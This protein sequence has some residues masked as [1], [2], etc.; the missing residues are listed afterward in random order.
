MQKEYIFVFVYS[1]FIIIKKVRFKGFNETASTDCK[2]IYSSRD[3][4]RYCFKKEYLLPGFDKKDKIYS[5]EIHQYFPKLRYDRMLIKLFSKC[6]F[7]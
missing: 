5:V 1:R 7:L 4:K 2:F 3:W 6:N